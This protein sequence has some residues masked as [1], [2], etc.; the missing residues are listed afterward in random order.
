MDSRKGQLSKVGEMLERHPTLG[1]VTTVISGLNIA[2]NL[3]V[4]YWNF[5]S[6]CPLILHC[7]QPCLQPRNPRFYGP[8]LSP[9]RTHCWS[10]LVPDKKVLGKDSDW[11]SSYHLP[12][13]ST[14]T[15]SE[16]RDEM[17]RRQSQLSMSLTVPSL[18]PYI[19]DTSVPRSTEKRK[20]RPDHPLQ[21]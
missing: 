11:L 13:A 14:G 15:V 21:V 16:K 4:S 1:S 17:V 9:L 3:P 20:G 10:F 7:L 18:C 2:E 8:L 19:S 12:P 5:F 6:A